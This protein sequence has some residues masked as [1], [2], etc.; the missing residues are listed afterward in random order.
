M[1]SNLMHNLTNPVQIYHHFEQH[2]EHGT[3]FEHFSFRDYAS[4]N[5]QGLPTYKLIGAAR[6]IKCYVEGT[7]VYWCECSTLD[8]TLRARI[9]IPSPPRNFVLQQY[10]LS[11]LLLSTKVYKLMANR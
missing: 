9:R 2:V 6:D 4:V 8:L 3:H 7:V 5:S 10:S 1:I 11:T